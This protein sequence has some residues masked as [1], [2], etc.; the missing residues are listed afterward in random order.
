MSDFQTLANG[1]A[2]RMR[3]DIACPRCGPGR[4]NPRSQM[5]PKLR[6]WRL[7]DTALS[8]HCARC[9]WS[10][11]IIDSLARQLS[12]ADRKIID[13]R[14]ERA[15]RKDAADAARKQ[16]FA[17]KLW[18]ESRDSARSAWVESYLGS[19]GLKLPPDDYE[20]RRC[21]RFHA[22]VPFPDDTSGPALLAGF[23]TIP[24]TIPRD[25]YDDP[26]VVALHRI[27]GRGA[28]KFMLCPT[29]GAAIQFGEWQT[30]CGVILH[31]AEGVETMLAVLAKGHFPC[32]AMGSAQAIASLPPLSYPRALMIWAD[33]DEVGLNAARQC[34]RRWADAGVPARVRYLTDGG[35]YADV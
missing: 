23:K 29:K 35:D 14:L 21:L 8:Y 1:L 18:R 7:S 17:A 9:G 24:L 5:A 12:D 13:L 25:P 28:N 31:I 15:R 4:S 33:A 26:P 20:R 10:G 3:A 6:V 34:A 11:H 19:R 27:R 22:N 16:E 30:A 32:W 2:G